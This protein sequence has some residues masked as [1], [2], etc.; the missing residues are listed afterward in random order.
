MSRVAPP[1][2]H[3]SAGDL[4]RA[5]AF[6]RALGW[7][8]RHPVTP[9]RARVVVRARL[10]AREESF[11]ALV[12]SRVFGDPGSPYRALLREAGCEYGDLERTVRA[13]GLDAALAGLYRAGVYL[14][15]PELR[16]RGEVRR[17]ATHIA[18]DLGRLRARTGRVRPPGWP[19]TGVRR[20]PRYR[21]L[22]IDTA[23][24]AMLPL[25]ARGG[26]GWLHAEWGWMQLSNVMWLARMSGPGYGPDR[27][28]TRIDPRAWP[29]PADQWLTRLARWT[30]RA[31][32][33]PWPRPEFA[34][35]DDPEPILAWV[36]RARE[37][38]HTPHL[39]APA[40]AVVSL[41]QAAERAGM[42]LA[43]VQFDATAEPLTAGRLAAIR[44]SG[45]VAVPGYGAKEAGML[46]YGC[47]TP[48]CSDDMHVH[49]DRLAIIQAGSENP[50]SGLPADA[51]LVTSLAES[52]PLVL[53]NVSLG[54]RGTIER[55]A[56]GC[57]LGTVG[58][59][60]HVHSVRSF[61]KLK[62]G[63]I[64]LAPEPLIRLFEE[65]LPRRFGG[66]PTDYQLVEEDAAV[67]AGTARIR[68]LIDP[69]VRT[70]EPGAAAGAFLTM[71][72]EAG[73]PFDWLWREP[74]WLT[75]ERRSP[76]V[77]AGGKIQH[78]HRTT[79]ERGPDARAAGEGL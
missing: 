57:G 79:A 69:A 44:R 45:G 54:D 35:L 64:P 46:A 62:I 33:K 28:F 75:V 13:D 9:D 14:T 72:R 6:L 32:G 18:V 12:R 39:R 2:R 21:A 59:T 63:G 60:T 68:L 7:Y 36:R 26:F 61:E 22:M 65:V 41:C 43:G 67:E 50:R 31:A 76:Y 27:Y 55:R 73:L 29:V 53:L 8:L 51:L 3:S 52:W 40:S 16:R 58:W 23:L 5:A 1:R 74:S 4:A 30:S 10:A 71:T 49:T 38:G 56:C 66:G 24:A 42:D 25:D 70:V 78:V 11:L 19:D 48:V 34:P 77:T 15:D 20:G 37:A 17:G 47:L